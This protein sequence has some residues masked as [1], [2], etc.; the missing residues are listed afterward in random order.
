MDTCHL[1][2]CMY[3]HSNVRKRALVAYI[4]PILLASTPHF[5]SSSVLSPPFHNFPTHS[6][7]HAGCS[8]CNDSQGSMW[9]M[10][11]YNNYHSSSGAPPRQFLLNDRRVHLIAGHG[12]QQ[13]RLSHWKRLYDRSDSEIYDRGLE[14]GTVFFAMLDVSELEH[15][16]LLRWIDA[17]RKNHRPNI[18]HPA[19]LFDRVQHPHV[20][21]Y[22]L[23]ELCSW[24]LRKTLYSTEY[25]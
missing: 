1:E 14:Q 6:N 19:D 17:E 10:K 20:E 3:T 11:T 22:R 15:Q 23:K 24:W 16:C 12:F 2:T 8:S 5:K 25:L 21:P 18:I 9:L 13:Y 7:P 4:Y